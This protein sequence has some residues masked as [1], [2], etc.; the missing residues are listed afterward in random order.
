[1]VDDLV[2]PT[3]PAEPIPMVTST[4]GEKHESSSVDQLTPVSPPWG[5]CTQDI[6]P[7]ELWLAPIPPTQPQ[8]LHRQ[9]SICDAAM[10][11]LDPQAI[12]TCHNCKEWLRDCESTGVCEN[13]VGGKQ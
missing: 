4:D 2:M 9:C 1:M 3:I 6:T 12:L 10:A 5:A 8:Y 11:A 7:V 13:R